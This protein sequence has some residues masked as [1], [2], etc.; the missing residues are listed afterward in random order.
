MPVSRP[1]PTMATTPTFS[2]AWRPARRWRTIRWREGS[3]GWLGAE[4][5]AVRVWRQDAQGHW[6]RGW[7]IGER[8]LARTSGARAYYWSNFPSTA[9]LERLVEYA[10]RRHHIER[11]HQDAKDELGWN[12]YQARLWAVFHRHAALVMLSYTFLVWQEWQQRHQQK[13][14]RGWPRGAFS[15]SAGSPPLLTRNDSSAGLRRTT[16]SGG[17]R[18][19]PNQ[20]YRSVSAPTE[21]TP[22][23]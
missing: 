7:L 15:P 2:M 5:H 17:R 10:H 13:P 16:V 21:L 11:F 19:H 14:R 1:M 3:R 6:Q 23:I 4:F 12:Q 22:A 20:P 9:P 18:T 8:P